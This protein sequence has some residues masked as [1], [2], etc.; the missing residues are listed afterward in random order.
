MVLNFIAVH[1]LFKEDVTSCCSLGRELFSPVAFCLQLN[2]SRA[3]EC[4][5]NVFVFFRSR[6]AVHGPEVQQQ[7]MGQEESELPSDKD[8][9][10]SLT[11]TSYQN[12]QGGLSPLSASGKKNTKGTLGLRRDVFFP[13]KSSELYAAVSFFRENFVSVVKKQRGFCRQV[14]FVKEI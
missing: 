13:Q 14:V 7:P 1:L 6:R 8:P 10:G 12:Q 11:L 2:L 9:E 5:I 4:S 3:P